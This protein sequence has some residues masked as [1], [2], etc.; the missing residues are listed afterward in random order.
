MNQVNFRDAR[1]RL[2]Q[3]LDEAEHGKS[4]MITRHGRQV[5]RLSPVEPAQSKRLPD[6]SEFRQS[7]RAKGP[8]LSKT[9]IQSRRL[10]R[11]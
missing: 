3:L 5:A 11:Y 4:V 1:R 2:T 9:V 8:A 6:L 7:V 10:E